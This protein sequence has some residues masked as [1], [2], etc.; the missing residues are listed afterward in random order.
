MNTIT[1][2][3][4][5]VCMLTPASRESQKKAMYIRAPTVMPFSTF[6]RPF[7]SIVRVSSGVSDLEL[8]HS[9]K[10]IRIAGCDLRA[11]SPHGA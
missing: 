11:G 1:H 3:R 5:K 9:L 6:T 7:A 4:S 8:S 10:V 2:T